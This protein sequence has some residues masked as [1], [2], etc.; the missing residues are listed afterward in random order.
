MR[1]T[2]LSLRQK[3]PGHTERSCKPFLVS[4]SPLDAVV[5]MGHGDVFE[6]DIAVDR[7]APVQSVALKR[8]FPHAG[9]FDDLDVVDRLCEEINLWI[10]VPW[11]RRDAIVAGDV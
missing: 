4:S 3:R 8:E 2:T 5:G 6:V 9:D 11:F 7:W 1:Y 10:D